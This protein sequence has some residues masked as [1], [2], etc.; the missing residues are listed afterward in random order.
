MTEKKAEK[1]LKLTPGKIRPSQ[2][3]VLSKEKINDDKKAYGKPNLEPGKS[4]SVSNT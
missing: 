3:Q 2:Q 1:Y 4:V